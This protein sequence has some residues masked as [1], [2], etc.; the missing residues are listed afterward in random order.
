VIG[1][2]GGYEQGGDTPEVSYSIVFGP[3][4]ANLYEQAQTAGS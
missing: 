2:I 4:V 1:V 3:N